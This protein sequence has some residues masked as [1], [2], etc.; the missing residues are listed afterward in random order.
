M[1]STVSDEKVADKIDAADKEK[2]VKECEA[3]LA[4][5]EGSREASKEEYDSRMKDLEGICTPI[6]TKMYQSGGGAPGGAGG[7]PG[8]GGMPGA[9]GARGPTVEEV[10]D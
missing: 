4:W 9:G 3:T 2:I 6:I 5:L 8:M 10:D 7:M 1:K